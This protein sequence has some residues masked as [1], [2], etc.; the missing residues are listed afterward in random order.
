MVVAAALVWVVRFGLAPCHVPIK[1]LGRAFLEDLVQS[2]ALLSPDW[3][4]RHRHDSG[5]GHAAVDTG[6]L[7]K[8]VFLGA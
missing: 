8:R 6:F 3:L 2:L 7:L 1:E 4:G 5:G